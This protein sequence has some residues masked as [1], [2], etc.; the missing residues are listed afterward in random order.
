M[1]IGAPPEKWDPS[2][3]VLSRFAKSEI[4]EMKIAVA[5]AADACVV[6]ANDGIDVSMNRYNGN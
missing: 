2:E 4:D 3:F 5:R 6:W 1:G